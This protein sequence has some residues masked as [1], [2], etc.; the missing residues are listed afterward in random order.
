ML[1]YLIV[2]RFFFFFVHVQMGVG[3]NMINPRYITNVF[4]KICL[5]YQHRI[6]DNLNSRGQFAI[7]H[8]VAQNCAGCHMAL[9]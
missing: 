6:C 1:G 8:H 5:P 2:Q 9:N 7:C 3:V 4:N